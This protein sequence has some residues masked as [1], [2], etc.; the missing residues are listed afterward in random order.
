MVAESPSLTIEQLLERNE[1]SDLL[2]FSTAGS[3]D[4]GKS[5]LIGRLL[6]DC[7]SVYEDQLHSVQNS[8]INRSTGPIDFSLLTD[9]LRAER[10]QGITIDVAYRYFST[11]RRKFI[12]ADTPGHE[13][14]TRNMATGASTA[15]L[16]VILIDARKGVLPQSRRHTYISSL[17]G[18]PY[19]AVAINKMDL[20]DF[21]EDVFRQIEAD[22]VAF[23]GPLGFRGI[24]VIPLS[25]LDG[26]N[27]ANRSSRT[28]WYSGPTLLEHLETVP[29]AAGTADAAFRLPVQYVVRPN[30]DFRGFAGQIAS[31]LLHPGDTVMALPSGRAS[32]VRAI[33]TY[34]GPLAEA[35]PPQ[36]VCVTLED[37]IDVS[38]GDML[39]DPVRPPHVSRRLTAS[40]V[41]MNE[42]PLETGRQYLLKHTSHSVSAVVTAI[43]SRVDVN[44]LEYSAASRLGLNEI[45]VVA[46]ETTRPLF[47]DA[48]RVNRSTGGFILI[49]PLSN[50]TLA[51]GMIHEPEH[52]PAARLNFETGRVTVNERYARNGHLAVSIW[53]TA[54]A[55]LAWLLERRLFE[56]GCQVQ[57]LAD[58]AE[59]ELLPALAKLL[60]SA[61]LIAICSAETHPE[62]SADT[63]VFQ[64]GELP[65][66]DADALEYVMKELDRRGVFLPSDFAAA[67]GI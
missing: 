46:I 52:A 13:Q 65:V 32:R 17:L 60:N 6:Y 57:A 59:N 15:S 16:A 25:A 21:R 48:Y 45:G 2:R 11:P 49:D 9:G 3:V 28:P 55:D 5:T 7:K 37:E 26:D 23:T 67:E 47:F 62:P 8:R 30:L 31:G 44:T 63:I 27:V 4:D 61:G 40:L 22:Y 54:R 43:R 56:R 51:A 18:I 58:D 66:R 29:V 64:P 20:M 33:S 19:L 10:E 14:Y 42:Q 53:L 36:S 12:I 24:Q 1:R 50:A 38:R 39:V 41:W 35:F 34:D